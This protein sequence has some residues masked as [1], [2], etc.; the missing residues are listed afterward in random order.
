MHALK[1]GVVLCNSSREQGE[2]QLKQ[3][4]EAGL[5]TF[6]CLQ[7]R[8]HPLQLCWDTLLHIA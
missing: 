6:I 8:L 3:L 7:A 4:L 1:D 2:A 5:T